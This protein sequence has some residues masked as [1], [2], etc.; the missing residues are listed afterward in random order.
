MY[1]QFFPFLKLSFSSHM[2]LH[3]IGSHDSLYSSRTTRANVNTI[4]IWYC[5]TLRGVNFAL[6]LKYHGIGMRLDGM[7]DKKTV[8]SRSL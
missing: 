2:I 3:R 5:T 4:N 7:D 6:F 8:E 1:A